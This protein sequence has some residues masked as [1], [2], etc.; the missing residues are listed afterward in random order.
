M[1]KTPAT[2][3]YIHTLF[4]GGG[5][6]G[7]DGG[8]ADTLHQ[9]LGSTIP[10]TGVSFR[11]AKDDGN[12]EGDDNNDDVHPGAVELPNGV[13]DDCDGVIDEIVVGLGIGEVPKIDKY[14][15]VDE[16]DELER[17]EGGKSFGGQV[18][19][20]AWW[21]R[22]PGGWQIGGAKSSPAALAPVAKSSPAALAP[23]AKSSPA[24]LAPVAKSS[25]AALAPEG[26]KTIDKVTEA[27][28]GDGGWQ[29]AAA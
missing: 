19:S 1:Q 28:E 21:H 17:K 24:A 13:D 8:S 7:D 22:R 14:K 27:D 11:G 10:T 12:D 2:R 26:G 20:A 25:P 9:Q 6:A 4:G 3:R 29:I 23:I 15:S 16:Y 18:A 5:A